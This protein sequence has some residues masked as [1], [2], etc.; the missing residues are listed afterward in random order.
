VRRLGS[1]WACAIA[2]AL[3]LSSAPLRAQDPPAD[4]PAATDASAP[5][6]EPAATPGAQE[7]PPGHPPVANG[8]PHA[9]VSAVLGNPQVSRASPSPEV[10]AG[11]IRVIVVDPQGRPV[12]DAAVDVGVL[13]QAGG[14]RSSVNG[15]TNENGV[16]TFARLATG[17]DQ[18]YRVN[19][20]YLGATYSSNPFQLPTEEGYDVRIVRQPVTR[21][22]RMVFF[23][24]FR[25]IVE[26]KDERLHVIHQAELTNAGRETYVFPA[27]GLRVPLPPGAI[28]FQSQRV[29]TDQRIEESDGSYVLRGSLPSGTVQL[30][31]AYDLPVTG[32]RMEIPV[33]IPMRVF[34]L[35]VISEAPDGL[36]L[37][38]PGLPPAQAVDDQGQPYWLT[39]VRRRPNEAP[40]EQLTVRIA[41]IPGPGPQRWFAVLLAVVAVVV[42]GVLYLMRDN[43]SAGAAEARQ[44]RREELLAEARELDEDLAAGEIG[45]EFRQS[46]RQEIVRELALL[47]HEEEV[48]REQGAG[49]A[50]G[51]KAS[52]PTPG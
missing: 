52:R 9:D 33:T 49:A 42:G 50:S 44:R 27:A 30:A 22:D 26:L 1:F 39:Q 34:G 14:E 46:R 31:W 8:S 5:A 45:P 38:V 18:A 37:V 7:M 6:V 35:Q 48:A 24:V 29:M 2:L 16:A 13:A 10:P 36:S 51:T 12:P 28:A 25:V 23:H 17:T 40:L 19:V 21:E 43:A 3:S 20:P 4:P 32:S 11:T 15:R 47:L 41:G